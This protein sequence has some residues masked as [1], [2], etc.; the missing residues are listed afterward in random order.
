MTLRPAN[1]ALPSPATS[2]ASATVTLCTGSAPKRAVKTRTA[3]AA[4]IEHAPPDLLVFRRPDRAHA[5]AAHVSLRRLQ[6]AP[7]D[8]RE[9]AQ[10]LSGKR[11]REIWFA[12]CSAG[13][14][15]SLARFA[16]G[17]QRDVGGRVNCHFI[18]G[19]FRR[20]RCRRPWRALA[21]PLVAVAHG[22]HGIS[23]AEHQHAARAKV[24][25]ARAARLARVAQGRA[26]LLD[27]VRREARLVRVNFRNGSFKRDLDL[28]GGSGSHGFAQV[29][30]QQRRSFVE[31]EGERGL[32]SA[33][34]RTLLISMRGSSATSAVVVA[35]AA[36]GRRGGAVRVVL[37]LLLRKF[38]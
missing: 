2:G 30:A 28:G 23:R 37:P 24:S 32:A 26:E 18:I 21:L 13:E 1:S 25:V 31:R 11:A 27:D 16:R 7:G 10:I 15:G 34:R 33:A 38:A 4:D 35:R 3:S 6:R 22:E 8:E 19:S 36:R 20:R 5:Y 12:S 9:V 17:E 29:D 14:V